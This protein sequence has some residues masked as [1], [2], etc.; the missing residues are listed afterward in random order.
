[1]AY[2]PSAYEARRRAL[3]NNYAYSGGQNVYQRFLDAQGAQRQYADLNTQFEQQAPKLVSA[4]GRRGHVGPNVKSGA[5]R[6]AMADFAKNR[7]KTMAEAQRGMNQSTQ[8]FDLEQRTRQDAL[9]NDLRDL[10][11]EKAREIDAAA[12]E[13]LRYRSGV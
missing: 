9:Q 8:G 3:M 2:D 5:F 10:E 1:M 4:W 6:K 12:Q 11:M 7:A 13:L